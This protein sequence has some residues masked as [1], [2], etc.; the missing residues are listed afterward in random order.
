MTTP[1]Y[2]LESLRAAY[3]AKTAL[4]LGELTLLPA[5]LYALTGPNGSGKSTL[6]NVLAFLHPPAAGRLVFN[7]TPVNWKRREL[8]ALRQR[9]TL[10]Q[11]SPLLFTGTVAGNVAYGLK[12]RGVGGAALRDRVASA[13]DEVG[14]VGFEARNARQLSGGEQRRVALARALV[15]GTEVLLLDEPLA[16][17]DER[18]VAIIERVIVALVRCGTTVVIATHDAAQCERLGAEV[19]RLPQRTNGAV[20]QM[21]PVYG[22]GEL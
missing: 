14:L 22:Y 16:N 9:V 4:E 2:Q 1:L 15:I 17:V 6:L 20:V 11:Q 13:L 8:A 18:S 7:G 10:M 12:L 19:I 3:G 21:R 5:R